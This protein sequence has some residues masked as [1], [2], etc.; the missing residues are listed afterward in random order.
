MEQQGSPFPAL[1][2]PGELAV[3]QNQIRVPLKFDRQSGGLSQEIPLTFHH[4]AVGSL[5]RGEWSGGVVPQDDRVVQAP[6]SLDHGSATAAASEDR[7]SQFPAT[8]QMDLC[9]SPLSAAEDHET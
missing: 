3:A 6:R 7:D 4:P 9:L 1:G 2:V 5:Y 8:L